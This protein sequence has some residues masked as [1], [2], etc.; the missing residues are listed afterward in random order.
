MTRVARQEFAKR[1]NSLGLGVPFMEDT[2]TNREVIIVYADKSALPD[3]QNVSADATA[4]TGIPLVSVEDATANCDSINVALVAV[5]KGLI[6]RQ[7]LALVGDADGAPYLHRFMRLPSSNNRNDVYPLS[8]K[9]P[10]RLAGS[11]HSHKG[12][13]GAYPALGPVSKQYREILGKYLQNLDDVLKKLSP[14][15]SAA[16][17]GKN[18]VVVMTSNFG[19]SEMLVNFVC[20]ARSRGLDLSSVL[21]FATD[22][23]TRDIALGLGLHAF[24]DEVNFGF[25]P[26][27]AAKKMQDKVFGT[28]V[29]YDLAICVFLSGR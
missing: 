11:L 23:E 2:K 15:A 27:E 25:I 29:R 22:E 18:M 13:H 7:C 12:W 19:Q 9:A 1:F 21:V 4:Q 16:A 3:D 10:L 5:K 17:A 8:P 28:V 6:R 26:R 14:I 24:Y 20:A